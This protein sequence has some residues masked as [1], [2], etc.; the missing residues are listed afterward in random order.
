MILIPNELAKQ[1]LRQL[2]IIIDGVDREQLL[3]SNRLF[4]SVRMTKKNI[5][6]L[7]KAYE[8]RRH[9]TVGGGLRQPH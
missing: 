9:T 6:R 4:N 7:R 8:D 1:L 5:K 3:A 2:P